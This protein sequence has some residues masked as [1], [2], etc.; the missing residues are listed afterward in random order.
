MQLLHITQ[1]DLSR[2]LR[3]LEA[4]LGCELFDRSPNSMTPNGCGRVAVARA[5]AVLS[6]YDDLVTAVA[7]EGHRCRPLRMGTRAP[8]PLRA[9]VA[10]ALGR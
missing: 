7:E 2:S 10:A 1:P 9:V 6:A 8:A 5:S 3:C 4:E